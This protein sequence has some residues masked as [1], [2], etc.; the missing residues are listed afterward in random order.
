ML[1][2]PFPAVNIE[3]AVGAGLFSGGLE[4]SPAFP[5]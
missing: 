1:L 4:M 5:S 3:G 2:P